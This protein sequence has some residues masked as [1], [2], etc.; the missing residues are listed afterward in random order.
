MTT[1][2]VFETLELAE[3]YLDNEPTA[4]A[5]LTNTPHPGMFTVTMHGEPE[6]GDY[7]DLMASRLR[8]EKR[9]ELADRELYEAD[10]LRAGS[11]GVGAELATERGLVGDA[12]DMFAKG[13][14][15]EAA[16]IANPRALGLEPVF[17][18][19][20]NAKNGSDAQ[21]RVRAAAHG[22][23]AGYPFSKFAAQKYYYTVT[24]YHVPE[25]N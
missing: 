12:A 6:F 11:Y 18:D 9:L 3:A 23:R 16:K 17:R 14:A 13:F 2:N 1:Q 10:L 19:G 21:R 8:Q 7:R 25:S 4:S 22:L 24:P 15:G 5:I 20:R